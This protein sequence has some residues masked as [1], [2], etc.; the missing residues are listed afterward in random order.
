MGEQLGFPCK[1]SMLGGLGIDAYFVLSVTSF[2]S[3]EWYVLGNGPAQSVS[4][5]E[6]GTS[7]ERPN[8]SGAGMHLSFAEH[9]LYQFDPPSTLKACKAVALGDALDPGPSDPGKIAIDLHANWGH[10]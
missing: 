2:R 3:K 5:F 4:W 9:G 6:L 1:I 7:A 10:A 8:F